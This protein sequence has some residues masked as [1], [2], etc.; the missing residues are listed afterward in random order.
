VPDQWLRHRSIALGPNLKSIIQLA[1]EFGSSLEATALAWAQLGLWRCAVVFWEKS[2]KPAEL[3]MLNQIQLP[4]LEEVK[5]APKFRVSRFFRTPNFSQ[6]IPRFKSA[7]DRSAIERAG[8]WGWASGA[9]DL[10]LD[11]GVLR[12]ECEAEAS[13]Y[14]RDGIQIPRV[15]SLVWLAGE[16]PAG[17]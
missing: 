17:A 16:K 7:D 4:G 3:R 13:Y 8:Q 10:E 2:L 1:N 14:N 9:L 15:M 6:Y 12:L 11:R 5:P